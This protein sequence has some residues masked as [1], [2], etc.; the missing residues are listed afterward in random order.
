MRK[1]CHQQVNLADDLR[2]LY[3]HLRQTVQYL[4]NLFNCLEM[5]PAAL[6]CQLNAVELCNIETTVFFNPLSLSMAHP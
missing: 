6:K 1:L 2:Q 4:H 5:T 3:S